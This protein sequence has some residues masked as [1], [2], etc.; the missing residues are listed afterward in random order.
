[1][2]CLN[3]EL[4][5]VNSEL[6]L[7]VADLTRANN[8]MSNLLAGTGIGTVVVDHDLRILRF[9]RTVTRILNLI[10]E[11]AGRPVNHIV[12]NIVDYEWLAR[13]IQSVLDTL[14]PKEVEVRSKS[15]EWYSMRILP[16]RTQDNRIEGAV[17]SFIDI[18]QAKL[19]QKALAEMEVT[20]KAALDNSQA[21]IVI[22]AAPGGAI[23]YLNDAGIL[24][25]ITERD[26]SFEGPALEQFQ[27]KMRLRD[28]EGGSL[29]AI[30]L[31][32]TRA[33]RYGETSSREFSVI[34][35]DGEVRFVLA[36][37]APILNEL[38]IPTAGIMISIDI[39]DSKRADQLKVN[40]LKELA[41]NQ[42]LEQSS[43]ELNRT[44]DELAR[45]KVRAEEATRAKS[46][47]LASMS[48]EIRTPMNGVI[49]MTGLLLGTSLTPEQQG[50][51]ET[52]RNSAE[53][54][55][56]IIN[57]ILDFSK[58]EAGKLELELIPFDLHAA[59]EDV[60]E[61]AAVNARD[62]D[63]ELLVLFDPH[64]PSHFL[65]DVGRIRQVLLN[66]VCNA[67]KFTLKGHVLVEA[68]VRQIAGPM[69]SVR[70]AVHDTGIGIP[71][72]R[73]DHLF[74]RF[75][76]VDSSTTRKYGGTGLGLAISSQLVSLMGGTLSVTSQVG[77]GST[78][79]FE[80][81]L[82]MHSEAIVREETPVNLEGVRVLIV[83]DHDICRFI[84]TRLCSSWGMR[85]AE[86]WSGEMALAMV[87][88]ARM[89]GDPYRVVCLD[90]KMPE[91]SGKDLAARLR[92][93]G[94]VGGPA[95]IFITSMDYQNVSADEGAAGADMCL[96]K[97]V[98][99]S[100][101]EESLRQILGVGDDGVKT[102]PPA[103][104]P[105][106]VEQ[107]EAK[108]FSERRIL[109]VEDNV[110]NQKLGATLLKKMGCQ[111]DIAANGE[112]A[113]AMASQMPFDLIFMDCQMPE[114]DGFQATAAIRKHEEEGARTPIVALTAGVYLDD[115]ERCRA[116]G[117]D[118]FL[119]KPIK[120]EDL[121]KMLTKYLTNNPS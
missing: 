112:E 76:Q 84:T 15:G 89:E 6:E 18:S 54:L 7:K 24:L 55:L 36:R 57:E 99:E 100:L 1:L 98:R 116:A 26:F 91:M 33:I 74:Q 92:P 12:S 111:V 77:T 102:L 87:E 105:M 108:E 53:A 120:V 32:L 38:G 121:H 85:T 117:M 47:F 35:D 48:H 30:D 62:K 90:Y 2:Q 67:V 63:L 69:A 31:P 4:A 107:L 40:Y 8:D 59:L 113:V 27:T 114:M 66:L 21:G 81:S 22:A 5:S 79:T 52:V 41:A 68:E 78:F 118:E 42:R 83:D 58:I 101:L 9:T 13:D 14:I 86:A 64:S 61:L 96:V 23:Q 29:T 45:A 16:Y 115:R 88:A 97:P 25:G 119:S 110:V 19:A 49:G 82:P 103:I 60:V 56:T 43:I 28:I 93:P 75:Q 17:I 95:I 65:G 34:G 10:P 94:T 51:A 109:L 70:I 37:G 72:D 11:D 73:L 80:I 71:A 44:V 104:Q 106:Q 20:L 46:D 3:E 50:Y 39:T